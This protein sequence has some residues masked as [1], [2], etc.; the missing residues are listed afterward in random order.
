MTSDS[1]VKVHVALPN[2]ASIG[3]ETF[4]ADQVGDSLYRLANVPFWAYGLNYRDVVRATPDSEGILTIYEVAEPSGHRTLRL[5]FS[6]DV[7]TEQQ[8]ELLGHILKP[9]TVTFER[10]ND[11]L[12]AINIAPDADYHSVFNQLEAWADS[13]LLD[14]ETCHQR[15]EG[16]FDDAP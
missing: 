2:H 9:N 14:F 8:S 7:G 13:D 12:I 6:S 3:G 11:S 16:S 1:G 15:V 5:M 10:A 4:W